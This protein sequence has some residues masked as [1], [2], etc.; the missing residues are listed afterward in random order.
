MRCGRWRR[1]Q[2]GE[3]WKAG[4]QIGQAGMPAPPAHHN[5]AIPVDWWPEPLKTHPMAPTTL[6][7]EQMQLLMPFSGPSN[8]SCCTTIGSSHG[9]HAGPIHHSSRDERR[10]RRRVTQRRRKWRLL[11]RP[12]DQRTETWPRLLAGPVRGQLV[13]FPHKLL[14]SAALQV[15]SWSD[16]CHDN[17]T[18]ERPLS[19]A[20]RDPAQPVARSRGN[21]G[22]FRSHLR[23]SLAGRFRRRRPGRQPLRNLC[24]LRRRT[25]Q[26]GRGVSCSPNTQY[27]G[28]L[29]R[30]DQ[31]R[32]P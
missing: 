2:F 28:R 20:G 6:G 3:A 32:L 9:P 18:R 5:H 31:R 26:R 25:L 13:G 24:V 23:Q 10:S 14:V 30:V 15:Y 29:A 21:V 1:P 7:G 27:L 22:C 16:C 4:H 19:H 17:S 11:L 12:S 8:A